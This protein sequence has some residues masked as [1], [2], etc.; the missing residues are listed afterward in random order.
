M[1]IPTAAD[2]LFRIE[3]GK[4]INLIALEDLVSEFGH[5]AFPGY[6][7]KGKAMLRVTRNADFDTD[8]DDADL[9]HDFDFP[10]T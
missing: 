7:V 6:E 8:V 10:N 4:K 9:E 3:G 5:Y 2:R 1:A